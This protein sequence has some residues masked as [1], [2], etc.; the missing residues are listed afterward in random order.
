MD[1]STPGFSVPH[2]LLTFAQVFMSTEL[3]MPSNISSSVSLF[4]FC[5]QAFPASRSFP[6]SQLFASGGQSM[7]ASASVLPMNVQGWFPLGLSDLISLL[8]KGL[9]RVFSNMF[10]SICSSVLCL[11][12]GPN[13]TSVHD[14]WQ[15]IAL[16]IWTL[17]G[18]V[19]SLLF[20]TLSRFVIAFLSRSNQFLVWRLQSHLQCF[21]SQKEG[22]CLCLHLFQLHLPWSDGTRCHDLYFLMLNFKPAFSLSTFIKRPYSSSLISAIMA[23]SSACLR[24]LITTS[25]SSSPAFHMMCS[26]WKLYKQGDRKQP[27]HIPFSIWNSQLFQV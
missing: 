24:M 1:C 11:L 17:V 3:V 25:S 14:H 19:M 8:S 22:I 2:H 27:C 7:G 5:P 4:S 12:Y 26:A 23:V 9:S 10:K 13:L 6:M 15:D 18:K 16:T 21:W 20:T